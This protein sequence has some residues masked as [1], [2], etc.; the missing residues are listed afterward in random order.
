M[1]TVKLELPNLFMAGDWE[2]DVYRL[3]WR[4]G[5]GFGYVDLWMDYA[6]K[7]VAAKQ[8]P[9]SGLAPAESLRFAL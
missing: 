1:T 4:G 3:W 5:E 7:L 6:G 2:G 9:T 8:R